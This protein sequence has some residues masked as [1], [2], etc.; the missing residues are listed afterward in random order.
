M[1]D[2]QRPT[3][4]A[5]RAARFFML[6]FALF[7]A[8][9]GFRPALAE[10][11]ITI[12]DV[13]VDVTAASAAAA[14]DQAIAEAQHKAFAMLVKKL[15]SDP[16]DQARVKPTGSQIESFVQGFAV[17]SERTS[18]VRYI[19][20]YSVR[21]RAGR[22]RQFL[23]D[24][25]VHAV[26]EIQEVLLVPLYRGP[27]G[28]AL[29]GPGNT[30]RT[31]W[32]RGGFG[33]DPVTLILPN[34]DRYDTGAVSASAAETGDVAAIALLIQRYRT[35]GLV[36]VEA[37]PHDP[38]RGPASGLTLTLSVYDIT[39]TKGSQ[40]LSVDAAPGDQ[41]DKIFDEGVA[42][43][44]TTLET[45]WQQAIAGGGSIG[46]VGTQPETTADLGPDSGLDTGATSGQPGTLF[47]IEMDISGL[48]D[49]L[50]VRDQLSTLPGVARLSLDALSRTRAAFTLDYAGDPL[51]LQA[52]LASTGFVLVQVPE[53][54][55]GA[56]GFQL[57]RAN[58]A[59][60]AAAP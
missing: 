40:T 47:P 49:W 23:Q 33:D 13:P 20:R 54:T 41:P 35:A 59:G 21:F 32:E 8:L 31:A 57:R 48:G 27:N 34:G 14:R 4:S 17:E 44:A 46:L 51:A 42:L 1:T 37:A 45:G 58:A 10:S 15:V 52:A 39:G 6:S 25:G 38:A 29:W 60:G 19:A 3:P 22:V 56:G 26:A 24:S 55:P 5:F 53:G 43:S 50:R 9:A 30:W 18:P 16:A 36:V 28:P 11:F 2:D 12:H 7:L